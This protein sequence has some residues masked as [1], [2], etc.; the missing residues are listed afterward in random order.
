MKKELLITLFRVSCLNS[1]YRRIAIYRIFLF[2]LSPIIILFCILI[3]L[4]VGRGF[5]GVSGSLVA[6]GRAFTKKTLVDYVFLSLHGR[7]ATFFEFVCAF[8]LVFIYNAIGWLIALIK[9][10]FFCYYF[11]IDVLLEICAGYI[12]ST[13]FSTWKLY[14]EVNT[15][16]VS[17]II[18]GEVE[19]RPQYIM[20]EYKFG[21]VKRNLIELPFVLVGVL[22]LCICAFVQVL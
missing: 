15:T 16:I 6:F 12:I 17:R 3:P 11:D 20:P 13:L 5:S 22:L 10:D 1:V 14:D 21:F 7:A 4:L 2:C 19:V 8:Y 18:S 9:G